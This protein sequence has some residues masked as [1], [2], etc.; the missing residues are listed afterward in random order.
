MKVDSTLMT[1]GVVV[2]IL[3]LLFMMPTEPGKS[4]GPLFFF[5][6]SPYSGPKAPRGGDDWRQRQD[7]TK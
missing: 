4:R 3:V 2:L 1:G 5:D 6:E 7:L